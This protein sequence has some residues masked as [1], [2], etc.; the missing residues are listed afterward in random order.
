MSWLEHKI[1]PPLVALLCAVLAWVL[2]RGTPALAFDWALRLPIAAVLVV[3]GLLLDLSALVLFLKA[4]TTVNP[5]TPQRASAIVRTGAYRFTR[6]PM[7]LGMAAILL[8]W[9]VLQSNPLTLLAWAAFVV[10]ITRFQII[11][12]ER[13]LLA[14]FGEDYAGYVR[15]VRRWV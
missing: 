5:L 3:V 12:E 2:A 15:A 7:Y 9:C 10:Y 14:R 8:G 1:P 4:R 13:A 11:P 6:N